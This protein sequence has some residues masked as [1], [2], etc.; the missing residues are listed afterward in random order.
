MADYQDIRDYK[1]QQLQDFLK[2]ISMLE[3]SGGK[4]IAHQEV[5]SGPQAGETAI[6]N[7]GLMPNTMKELAV[8][9]PSPVTNGLSKDELELSALVDPKF[10]NTMAGSMADYLKNKRGLSDEEAAAAWEAG[11]NK[12]PEDLD[13]NSPRAKKFRVLSGK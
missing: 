2:K 6:G 10:A 5:E 1:S 9:Y 13:L 3:S 4:N 8:R 7:Y 11:H 12:N